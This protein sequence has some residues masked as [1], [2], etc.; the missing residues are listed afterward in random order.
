VNI[1][2][3]VL[4]ERSVKRGFTTLCRLVWPSARHITLPIIKIRH[5]PDSYSSDFMDWINKHYTQIQ[6][7]AHGLLEHF[8]TP[9][10]SRIL[11]PH[12]FCQHIRQF[13][14]AYFRCEKFSRPLIAQ[15]YDLEY[16]KG[17]G[18]RHPNSYNT[19]CYRQNTHT[20]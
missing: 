20:R 14:S 16:I 17:I 2:P 11:L 13:L 9:N 5:I 8:I 1:G 15:I 18:A 19:Q 4:A 6:R 3:S 10:N 12:I 7:T